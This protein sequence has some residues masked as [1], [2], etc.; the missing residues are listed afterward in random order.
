MAFGREQDHASLGT[1]NLELD[2]ALRSHWLIRKD[3]ETQFL[4]VELELGRLIANRNADELHSRNHVPASV[5]GVLTVRNCAGLFKDRS[6]C[7]SIACHSMAAS[8]R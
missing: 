4:G 1:R 8:F 6:G 7:Y 3:L 5:S 2:P